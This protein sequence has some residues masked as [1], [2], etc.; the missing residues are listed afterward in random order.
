MTEPLPNWAPAGLDL[1]VPSA[2]RMYDYYL[3]GAHNF[4]VDRDLANQV[5]RLIPDGR[6]NAKANRAFLHRAV[7]YLVGQG[8]RQFI[9]LGSG[10]PTV[11]NVHETAQTL[12]PETRVLYVDH[13]PIAVTHSE[14]ILADNPTTAVLHADLRRPADILNSGQLARLIDLSQP[15]AVLMVAVLHFIPEKDQP[16][17][18]I[19]AF[20]DAVAP[21]SYLTLSHVSGH[22]RAQTADEAADLYRS[23][24]DTLTLRGRDQVRDLLTGWELVAPG[25]VWAP[26]WHP[27]WPDEVGADPSTCS[28]NVGIGQKP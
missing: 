21:G 15:V 19:Q 13:D 16:H 25:V 22:G 10:I 5:L 8:I 2:A 18:A 24:A 1:T 14:L 7:R 3:G 27:D 11:G 9:D 6:S 17:A 4:A 28:I 20:H 12:A 23:A 26:E